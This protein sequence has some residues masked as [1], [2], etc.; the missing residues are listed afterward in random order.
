MSTQA[1]DVRARRLAPW[2]PGDGAL[3]ARGRSAPL[4][5]PEPA[6]GRWETLA[7]SLADDTYVYQQPLDARSGAR[8]TSGG[9]HFLMLSS[10][11]YLGLIGDPRIEAASVAAVRRYGTSTGGVRL[12]TGTTELH[13]LLESELA[14]FKGTEAALCVSSGYMA[15]L[16]AIAA[17][18]GPRDR[19]LADERAHRSLIDACAVAR[20]PL[21][22]Y[23]HEDLGDLER[24]LARG[25][26]RRTL[27][28]AEGVYSMDGDVCALPA[29][30]AL[31][32][33]YGA[34]LLV[35]ESHSIGV[36]GRRG[37]GVDEHHGVGADEVDLWTGALS[38]AI[39][40]NGGFVAGSREL[41]VYLQH[42]AAPFVF[43]SAPCPA[44][45]AAAR[46]GLEAA[47]GEPA[48]RARM[49]ENATRLRDG[50]RALGYDTG[51]STSAIVPVIVG[52]DRAAFALARGLFDRGILA[53][54]VVHPAVPAG[55]AR[56]R[57]CATAA[58]RDEDVAEALDAFRAL[59]GGR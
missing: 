43:S 58:H 25:R 24:H 53:T 15:N 28:V 45:T 52:T 5:Q 50:L 2:R 59:G 33:R 39:P 21:V 37:R 23:A 17:L 38:K 12:L 54:P 22:R 1:A 56:L 41:V 35:D 48:R 18:F 51:D 44:A 16:A 9:R 26:S 6:R 40:S 7:A 36:L 47:F 4:L 29:L 30:V 3:V 19:V 27:V 13:H 11:D 14:A 46:A 57:L 42:A 31:K 34:Y 49:Q 10:Y 20:V 55:G 8:V 32:R